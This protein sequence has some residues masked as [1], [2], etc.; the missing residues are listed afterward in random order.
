MA[1]HASTLT[2]NSGGPLPSL[3][4]H[5]SPLVPDRYPAMVPRNVQRPL[6]HRAGTDLVLVFHG[7]GS[8]VPF[9]IQRICYREIVGTPRYVDSIFRFLELFIRFTP[10]SGW[11][12]FYITFLLNTVEAG[13]FLYL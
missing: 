13:P 7:N 5:V 12:G 4:S 11:F 8:R 1:A 2:L 10:L 9:S 6:L 3:P